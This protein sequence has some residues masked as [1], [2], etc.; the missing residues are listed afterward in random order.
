[1]KEITV[2]SAKSTPGQLTYGFIDVLD[3]PTG[4]EEKIPVM[5]AQGESDGPTFFLSAN[6]HG[7]ELTGVAV[8]HETITEQLAKELKGTVVALPTINPSGL[9][10][11]TRNPAYDARDPNRLFPEGRFA[12]EDYES[13]DKLYPKPYEQIANQIFSYF[14]KY[15]DY[16]LDFHNHSIRSIPYSILDRVF[17]KDESEKPKA[18]ELAQKQKEMVEAFGM[19]ASADFPAKKYLHLKYHRSLSGSVLNNLRIPAFTVE[20]GANSILVPEVLAASV[21]GTRNLLRWADMLEGPVEKITEIDI[22]QPKYRL[23]R[24]EH[25]RAAQAGII[26]ILVDPGQFVEKGSQ[27]AKFTDILGR[28]IGDGYIRTDYE[29]YMIALRSEMTVYK[30]TIVAEMGIKDVEDMLVLIPE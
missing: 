29:G 17:Y 25:P 12:K 20:L 26:K 27:I 16:H 5:I 13:D 22:P 2:G 3:Y 1:M 9:R 21:K 4:G 18:E 14:E 6:V 15:A 30:H 10:E 28:P 23:Q 11:Y 19:M 7:N 24:I 8:I